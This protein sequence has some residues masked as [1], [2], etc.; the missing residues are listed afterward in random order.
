MSLRPPTLGPLA[1]GQPE[2]VAPHRRKVRRSSREGKT[3]YRVAPNGIPEPVTRR[4]G[5][6]KQCLTQ[7]MAAN[8]QVLQPPR[9]E[10]ATYWT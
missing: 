1:R 8:G 2:R 4:N 7:T 3:V 5:S 10:V 9:V 6:S